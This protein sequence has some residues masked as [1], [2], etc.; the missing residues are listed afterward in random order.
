MTLDLSWRNK[1]QREQ[2]KVYRRLREEMATAFNCFD[3]DEVL[4]RAMILRASKMLGPRHVEE[5][6]DYAVVRMQ[7]IRKAQGWQG[8]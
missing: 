4:A 5:L 3:V 1:Y 8:A 2:D 6:A 7:A